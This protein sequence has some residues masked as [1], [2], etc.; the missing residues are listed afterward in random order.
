[1]AAAPD[2]PYTP[3]T[4]ANRIQAINACAVSCDFQRRNEDVSE[5]SIVLPFSAVAVLGVHLGAVI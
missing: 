4:Q 1:M 5:R 3:R 2:T